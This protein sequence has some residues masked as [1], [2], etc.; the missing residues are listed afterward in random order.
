MYDVSQKKKVYE[1]M[2]SDL[3][4]FPFSTSFSVKGDR[5]GVALTSTA[6]LQW[7]LGQAKSLTTEGSPLQH[8]M[9]LKKNEQPRS[10]S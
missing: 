10:T 4:Y 8:K 2:S 7:S 6:H 1:M 9:E 3:F 5:L